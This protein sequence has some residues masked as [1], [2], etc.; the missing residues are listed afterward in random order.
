M[1]YSVCRMVHIKDPLLLIEKR[2]A[3]SGGN[4]LSLT[5]EMVFCRMSDADIMLSGRRF[6]HGAVGHRIDPTRWTIHIHQS[7]HLSL[8]SSSIK[9]ITLY[10][11][12]TDNFKALKELNMCGL[13]QAFNYIFLNTESSQGSSTM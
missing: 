13:K 1:C 5:V 7:I 11:I 6:V 3:L 4:G 8:C 9:H 12:M 10:L 2:V